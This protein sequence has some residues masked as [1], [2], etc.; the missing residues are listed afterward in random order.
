MLNIGYLPTQ[1]DLTGT[2]D[3][4]YLMVGGWPESEVYSYLPILGGSVSMMMV[5]I[6]I[7]VVRMRTKVRAPMI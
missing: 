3:Q 2:P 5:L 7:S 4:V 1:V 6:F